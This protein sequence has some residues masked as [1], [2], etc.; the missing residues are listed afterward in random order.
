[1]AEQYLDPQPDA[2]KKIKHIVVLMLEN[3]SFDNL[4]GW[5]Y[6]EQDPPDGQYF[7]G[8]RKDMWNP[9]SNVDSNGVPFTEQVYV[10]K[11]GQKPAKGPWAQLHKRKYSENFQQPNPDPG[12]GFKD[13]NQQLFGTY[14]V[15]NL[16]PPDPTN[17]G[18]VNNYKD[19]MLYGAYSFGDTPTDP[20]DIMACY[21]PEQVPVLSQLAREFCVLDQYHCS[22][23]SQ[24]IPNRDFVHAATSSGLVNNGPNDTCDAK[25]IFNLIQ[26]AIE[27][28]NRSDLSWRI[29]CGEKWDKDKHDM[30]LF[31]LTQ[32]IM[33]QIQDEKYQ[34]NIQ[35]IDDFY[36]AAKDGKLP[37]YSF[38]EP[39]FSGPNQND[40]HPSQDIR[41]GEK[42]IADVYNAVIN[43]PA[44][45]ETMLVITYD[46]HGGCFD[47]VPPPGEAMPPDGKPGTPGQD[48]FLFNRFGVRVPA[49][50]VSP[51][52]RNGLIA[53]PSGYTPFDHTSIIATI[54]H[55]F[56][57]SHHLTERDRNAPDLSCVLTNKYPRR[58]KPEVKPLSW[59]SRNWDKH[60]YN[61]LNDH[62]AKKLH[63]LSGLT[64]QQG[65]S[66]H[67]YIHRAYHEHFVKR[68]TANKSQ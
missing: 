16:Y 24:T 66:T 7:E 36:Q 64:K 23:P 31:S 68:S 30:Q 59:E 50:V 18:F 65:E 40:Q 55:C 47:H 6:D 4:L 17:M 2:L 1:M 19:A 5:L 10:R 53:R 54:R 42:L 41:P 26:D 57:L 61:D 52:V 46:E 45:D 38:L 67:D 11:N 27:Q 39:N 14:D 44:W 49:V 12:E 58:D 34:P 35:Y 33:T 8:L 3:R 25:T 62:S 20:R 43:S 21:T 51:Y 29:Y 48:G 22:V 9:L 37:S 28:E 63:E 32:T 56:D 15:A 13:T 60:D